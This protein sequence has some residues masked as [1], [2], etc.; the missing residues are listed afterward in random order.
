MA[1]ICEDA[2]KLHS[3]ISAGG[4]RFH[5][6]YTFS[7]GP[8]VSAAQRAVV[9]RCMRLLGARLGSEKDV[10]RLL[11]DTLAN[12]LAS[13]SFSDAGFASAFRQGLTTSAQIVR[14]VVAPNYAF[15]LSPGLDIVTVGPVAIRRGS[16]IVDEVMSWDS[17]GKWKIKT[18]EG[19]PGLAVVD[20][21]PEIAVANCCFDVSVL[22]AQQN[23]DE[24]AFWVVD[25]ATSL[26]RLM[27]PDWE[28]YAPSIGQVEATAVVRPKGS[29]GTAKLVEKTI[30]AGGWSLPGFYV[31][32]AN[33]AA[34]IA[35][36][37]FQARAKSILSPAPNS[38][39][40]R[41]AQALGWLTRGR[42]SF[43]RAQRLLFFFTALEAILSSDDKSAPVIQ[44]I[45]R[46]AGVVWT[47][48]VAGRA[49]L[50]DTVKRL[51]AARSA[52]VHAGSRQVSKSDADSIQYIVEG[53]IFRVLKEI[54]LALPY[55]QLV[56]ELSTASHGLPW[57]PKGI[58]QDR[59]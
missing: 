51:Y 40:E 53:I 41:A 19:E 23:A 42:Q 15:R 17:L 32:G 30:Q 33:Q 36:A 1:N 7:V 55:A 54:D 37:S 16:S 11:W 14:R 5:Q 18:T 9:D 29:T 57:K 8:D 28:S 6:G 47:N 26:L 49:K 50:A 31:L 38:V 13:G 39:G 3:A 24:E 25:V 27:V 2:A 22:A 46:H 34:Q 43:E 58:D 20:G 12:E 44:T 48:D 56:S 59:S 10:E 52:L 4:F 21:T 45:A 35:D